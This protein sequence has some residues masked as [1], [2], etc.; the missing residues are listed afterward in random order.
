MNVLRTSAA[1]LLVA[2]AVAAQ[3]APDTIESARVVIR[4]VVRHKPLLERARDTVEKAVDFFAQ[5]QPYKLPKDQ[6]IVINL[7]ATGEQYAAAVRPAGGEGFL[8]SW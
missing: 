5:Q 7:Y 2:G 1:L 6:K 8:D 3:E 4:S